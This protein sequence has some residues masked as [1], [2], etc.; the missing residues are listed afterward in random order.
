MSCKNYPH[1]HIMIKIM[2]CSNDNEIYTGMIETEALYADNIENSHSASTIRDIIN[3][4][5]NNRYISEEDADATIAWNG[6]ILDPN[7]FIR[8]III[9]GKKIPL[10]VHLPSDAVILRYWTIRK[11]LS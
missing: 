3:V 2:D 4:W 6:E 5:R 8:N 7:M 10:Y 11:Q 1:Y 9:K